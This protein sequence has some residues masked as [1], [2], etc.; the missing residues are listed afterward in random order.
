MVSAKAETPLFLMENITVMLC[1]HLQLCSLV[2]FSAGQGEDGKLPGF[3]LQKSGC[4][5]GQGKYRVLFCS[6][7]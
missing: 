1:L 5:K 7:M 3:H 2:F 4:L 6:E